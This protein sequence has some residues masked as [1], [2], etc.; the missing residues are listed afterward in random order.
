ML[1]H[2]L[3]I[4]AMGI[5][6]AEGPQDGAAMAP[7]AE[8]AESAAAAQPAFEPED[9]TPTGRFTTAAEVKPILAVTRNNWIHV[10]DYNGQDLVYVTHLLSWRCGLKQIEWNVNDGDWQAWPMPPCHEDEPAP[11]ALK[12]GDGLPY[13]ALP[14]G[15][16]E[17]VGIRLIYDDL[18]A[19]A[20]R[21]ARTGMEIR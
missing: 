15:S 6:A 10:R 4:I 9:Q 1:H 18:S 19:D 11:N 16:V 14:Q 3:L 20:G 13:V 5:G 2:I 12:E 21:F 8:S 17:T 7:G